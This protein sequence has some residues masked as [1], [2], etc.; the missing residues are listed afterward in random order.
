MQ[1]VSLDDNCAVPMIY[2]PYSENLGQVDSG[3]HTVHFTLYGN[4]FNSFGPVHLAD[5]QHEYISP[6]VWRT[7][8]DKWCYEYQL[9]RLGILTTPKITLI[10]K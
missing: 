10:K 5:E 3:S 4:R 9:R 6:E 8:G 7:S 2:P 1:E